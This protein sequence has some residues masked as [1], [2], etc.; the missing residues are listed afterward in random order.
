MVRSRL[1]KE[2]SP[3]TLDAL[4]AD[5]SRLS[6]PGI[7]GFYN[8]C[9]VTEVIG[10][11][12]DKSP[13]NLF[14]IVVFEER[15]EFP[16]NSPIFL[17]LKPIQITN[18]KNW[19]FGVAR[20]SVEEKKL[21]NQLHEF[22]KGNV[23]QLSGNQIKTGGLIPA[24]PL[25]IPP[26]ATE[27]S[28][29]NR[30]LKNNFW[31]GCYVFE[32]FDCE[33]KLFSPLLEKADSLHQ[34][35]EAVQKYVPM[36]LASLSDRLGNI[37]IQLPVTAVLT[38]FSF[39]G[40]RGMRVSSDW[41]SRSKRRLCRLISS[42]E[43]DGGIAG[44]G[45]V[46]VKGKVADVVTGD[47][48]QLNRAILWDDEEQLILAA[49]GVVKPIGQVH[50]QLQLGAPEPRIVAIPVSGTEPVIHR[51]QVVSLP[52]E[53]IVGDPDPFEYRKWSDLR[54]YQEERKRLERDRVFVQ[55][56][57]NTDKE[58]ERQRALVDL[59]LLINTHGKQGVWLWDPYLTYAD[60]MQ[61]LFFCVYHTADLRALACKKLKN[62][63][64]EDWR[65]EQKLGFTT[66]G[67]NHYGLNLEFRLRHGSKGWAF[68]DRFLIFPKTNERALAWSIGTSINSL[69]A[70]HHILHRMDNGQ[71]IAD[72]FQELWETLDGDDFQV[73]RTR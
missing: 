57:L 40:D 59:R 7:L 25:Y 42:M 63:T 70:E 26:D 15:Q 41:D 55:Y 14:S 71:N 3:T 10:F 43:F 34:L 9:E 68:H 11:G 67:N 24:R 61:T 16:S 21:L 38:N 73:W 49:S 64:F 66:S 37:I 6:T 54:I 60:I 72:A 44:F 39:L 20:Y 56:G 58:A 50:L 2:A 31:N 48:S 36:R 12:P 62:K 18:L 45:V 46:D 47:S 1:S 30:V 8:S 13:V 65:R 35:S 4:I 32:L 28:P 51:I 33:K 53:S 23:W 5:L 69:G 22:K 17:N 19:T 27:N 52:A 29:L